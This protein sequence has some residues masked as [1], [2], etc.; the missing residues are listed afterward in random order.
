MTLE[1]RRI[2]FL[3][4][5]SFLVCIGCTES[6]SKSAEEFSLG[7]FCARTWPVSLEETDHVIN[8]SPILDAADPEKLIVG[9]FKEAQLRLYASDGRL[10]GH[11]GRRGSGPG[12]FENI[13][14][15]SHLPP[16]SESVL[17]T[18]ASGVLKSMKLDGSLERSQPT[19][20]GTAYSATPLTDSTVLIAGH[21]VGSARPW[22]LH[23]WNTRARSVVTSFF[24]APSQAA[25][26]NFPTF[27]FGWTAFD[28]MGTGRRSPPRTRYPTQ[29]TSSHSMAGRAESCP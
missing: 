20:I 27:A 18:D 21:L 12:E 22:L 15:I 7:T 2:V 10:I 16:D 19:S 8:V 29:S 5:A 28:L 17:V 3:P 4:I 9:D 1:V 13:I 23:V 14:S 24:S 25:S 11:F 6:L 26:L